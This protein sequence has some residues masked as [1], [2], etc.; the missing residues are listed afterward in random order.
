[1]KQ[2]FW[3]SEKKLVRI[4][5]SSRERNLEGVFS[6]ER[7]TPSVHVLVLKITAPFACLGRSFSRV[8]IVSCMLLFFFGC[9]SPIALHRA[10]LEYDR[11]VSRVEAELLLL[12]IARARYDHPIHFTAVSSIAATFDFRVN[13]GFA[14]N[15]TENPGLDTLTLSFGSSAAENPTVSIIP[16]QGEEFTKRLLTPMDESKLQFLIQQGIEPA[17]PLRLMCRGILL[18]GYGESGFLLNLPHQKD[19]YEEFRRR[20][21]H[22]SA[23]N[24]ARQLYIST[25]Q[26]S[27]DSGTVFGRVAITNYDPMEIS[28]D[29]RRNMIEKS[30]Q[31]S[32][33]YVLVDIRPDGPGGT[34]PL[35]GMLMLRSFKSILG[36]LGRGIVH[37]PE[38]PVEKDP[39]TGP[40]LR[41]ATQTL[42]IQESEALPQDATFSVKYNDRWYWIVN[43]SEHI[44]TLPSWNNEA[45]DVLYQLF[46]MTVTDVTR[47]P[48]P[49]ITIA[50]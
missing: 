47:A 19:E 4:T 23:L 37:E 11:T 38:F 35:H 1:M 40:I 14:G 46:Q 7:R 42:N 10:V 41:N 22:L 12:N 9:V 20:V 18:N 5:D 36:F 49:S 33:E 44:K 25:I 6:S 43:G 45:F 34:Y 48:V 13:T 26:Y 32:R 16:I 31:F 27:N 50:K 15:L 28:N 39:R 2:G 30:Q 17:I 29:E 8:I 3:V 21:L 24:L